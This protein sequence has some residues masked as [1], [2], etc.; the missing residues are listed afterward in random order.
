MS[1]IGQFRDVEHQGHD[2]IINTEWCNIGS[3]H[4]PKTEFDALLDQQSNNP[5]VHSF[6]KMT[7]GMYLGEIARQVLVHLINE[8]VLS[9]DLDQEEDDEC[10]LLL[11]YQFDT[12][13]MYVCEA[14]VDDLED[15]RL[16]LE[17][18]CRVGETTL[19]DRRIVK[20]VCELVGHRAALLLGAGI[21]SVVKYMVEYGI[22]IDD[23]QGFA[24]GKLPVSVCR[25]PLTRCIAISGDVYK[26]YPSFHPRVCEAIKDLI[27]EQVASKLSVGIVQHSRIVGAAIV[28][29]MAEKMDQQD[30]VMD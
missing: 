21:A 6:E 30:T 27:P 8:K 17:D 20:K 12:S 4:L 28:A 2:M 18:M 3:R 7:T 22:G 16:V 29:M 26:D 10:L 19:E 25:A 14:D 1:N 9:F 23:D 24:I 11:P 5:G 15:T 13:Y